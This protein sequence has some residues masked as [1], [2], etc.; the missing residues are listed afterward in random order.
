MYVFHTHMC[1]C[2]FATLVGFFLAHL[3]AAAC[4]MQ[5][6]ISTSFSFWEKEMGIQREEG[7]ERG[8]SGEG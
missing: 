1:V 2:V 3:Q 8:K 5:M 7:E 6:N 4:A